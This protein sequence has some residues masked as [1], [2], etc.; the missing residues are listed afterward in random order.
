MRSDDGT[1]QQKVS[2]D[3]PTGRSH[4]PL[5]LSDGRLAYV[6]EHINPGQSWTD[7]WATTPGSGQAPAAA[8][9]RPGAGAVRVQS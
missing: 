1:D 9:G 6:T 3:D 7:I 5:Y 2:H 8:T 4:F